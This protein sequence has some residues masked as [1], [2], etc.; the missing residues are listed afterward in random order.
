M[1]LVEE[2][3]ERGA[4]YTA[5]AGWSEAEL[6]EL[7]KFLVWKVNDHRYGD[8]LVEVCRITIDMYSAVFG[9]SKKIKGLVNELQNAVNKHIEL[10]EGLLELNGQIDLLKMLYAQK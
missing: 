2:L 1:A 8:I 5:M 10:A 6:E 3:A 7:L 9:L 4:L